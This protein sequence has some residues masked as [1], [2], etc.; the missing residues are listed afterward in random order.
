MTKLMGRYI[1]KNRS[2]DECSIVW[3]KL[4]SETPPADGVKEGVAVGEGVGFDDGAVVGPE[5]GAAVGAD[6]GTSVG[7]DDGIVEGPGDGAVVGLEDGVV[8][9]ATLY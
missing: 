2:G 4:Y 9:R 6:D 7:P 5:D 8:I 3:P 1:G